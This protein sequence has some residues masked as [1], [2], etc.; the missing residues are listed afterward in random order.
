MDFNNWFI[1]MRHHMI[2]IAHGQTKMY[3]FAVQYRF[4]M[5]KRESSLTIV[6]ERE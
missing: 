5:H 6:S 4:A 3:W 1:M 2:M